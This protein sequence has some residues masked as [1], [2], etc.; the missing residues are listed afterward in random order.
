MSNLVDLA[1]QYPLLIVAVVAIL[2]A[3]AGW[4]LERDHPA[5]ASLLRRF[6]YLGLIAVLLLQVG[7]SAMEAEKSDAAFEFGSRPT[8]TVK[9][10]ETIVPMASD[11]HFW[12]EAEINGQAHEFLIDTGASFTGMGRAAAQ[13][14]GITS[15]QDILPLELETANGTIQATIGRARSLSFGGI[16]VQNLEVAVPVR[17]LDKTNVIGMNLLSQLASWRVEGNKLILVPKG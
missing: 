17:G 2:L 11:G 13:A 14:A 6:G 9:G 10:S 12:V 5:R 16:T 7:I 3:T 4:M 15:A 8:V 1:T